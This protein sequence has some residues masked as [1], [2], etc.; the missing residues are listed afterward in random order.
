MKRE[1]PQVSIVT[2]KLVKD[3]A[4]FRRIVSIVHNI[5]ETGIPQEYQNSFP[6]MT[7]FVAD[8]TKTPGLALFFKEE[9]KELTDL[10]RIVAEDI[11]T[12]ERWQQ[13]LTQLTEAKQKLITCYERLDRL[14]EEWSGEETFEI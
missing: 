13:I 6:R 4:K 9:G 3:N 1:K 5:P 8:R 14:E 7:K 12:E 2:Q 10:A 11:F